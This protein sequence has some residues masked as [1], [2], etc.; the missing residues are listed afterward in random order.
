MKKLLIITFLSFSILHMVAQNESD[1]LRLS[2][3]NIQGTAR[4]MAMGGAFGALGADFSSLSTN[5]AGLGLYRSSEFTL[6]PEIYYRKTGSTYNG[7][8]G[9]G[10]RSNFDLSNVGFVVTTKM[11]EGVKTNPVKFYQF[12]FGMNRTNT[13]NNSF[14]ANGDNYDHSRVD[15]YLD[16]LGT[17]NPAEIETNFPFDLYPAWYVYVLD[18]VR[19]DFGDLYYTS[20]VPQGGIRQEE[21][22]ETKGSVNEWLFSAGANL[23]DYVYVGATLGMPHSRFLRTS[24]YTEYDQADTIPGFEEWSYSEYLETRGWG[25]NLKL[26]IIVWPV[27]FLRLGAAIHTPTYYGMTDNWY[28]S[29]D[30]RLGG[31]Y[32]RNDSPN[33]TYEYNLR[34][35][36]RALGSAA[37]IIG[38]I[39]LLSF[40]YE[41]VDYSSAKLNAVDYTFGTENAAIRDS[42]TSTSNLR[43][44]T[45]WRVNMLSFRGGYAL[46]GNPF[47][48]SINDAILKSYSLGLGYQQDGFGLDFAWVHGQKS[49]DYY[50]YASENYT[51][52][53]VT[54]DLVSNNFV[55]TMR[56]KF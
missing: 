47:S 56:M 28:T 52:N 29:T 48:V 40:D 27:E 36:M 1:A 19:D 38:K 35:P 25:I 3:N 22:Q 14:L 53:L 37:L 4:S 6:S 15:L 54:Q 50:L 51:T 39:G 9:E 5:P 10:D 2:Q 30:S 42:Y 43:F 31:V 17:T 24:N 11:P 41:Y 18:T 21:Y 23:N 46:Q 13:F 16:K 34:T 33:G 8:Y 12:A 55:L 20:P 7:M 45:E 32:N 26:G 49:Q 44:G